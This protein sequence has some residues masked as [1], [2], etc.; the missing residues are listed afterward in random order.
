MIGFRLF[1]IVMTILALAMLCFG[2]YWMITISIVI[3]EIQPD[4]NSYYVDGYLIDVE[5]VGGASGYKARTVFF[6]NDSRVINVVD[7][8]QVSVELN[9][10][11]RLELQKSKDGELEYLIGVNN[12]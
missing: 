3:D 10:Y 2:V 5:Y 9:T 11:I 4:G 6:F 12:E 7:Y 8:N 1:L